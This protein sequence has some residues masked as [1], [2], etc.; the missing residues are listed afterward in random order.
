MTKPLRFAPLIRVST[1]KQEKKGESLNTQKIQIQD[2]VERLGGV[3][4]DN[5][6]RYSGQEHATQDQERVKL[7]NLLQDSSKGLFDAI[8]VTDASRWSRDNKKSEEGLEIL[9][10]NSIQF[11]TGMTEINLFNP[12]NVLLLK[13]SVV[14]GEFNANIQTSKSLHNRIERAKRGIPTGGKPPYG[15]IFNKQTL[16]WEIDPD[17]QKGI[18]YAARRYLAGG[19]IPKIAKT[20]GISGPYLQTVLSKRSG[21]NWEIRFKSDRLKIDET[22]KFKVPR[23]LPQKTID[24]VIEQAQ[25]NKTYTHGEIKNKYLL[26][27]MIFCDQC[28]YAMY[29]KTIS[30]GKKYYIHRKDKGTL[31]NW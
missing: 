26:S 13:M 19:S 5:C 11:F 8:I 22:V 30:S 6:G 9:K 18:E 27:R 31:I 12:E 23:L 3:I 21:E 4:P 16:G 24:A 15:R 28:G 7:D 2:Y 25:S 20:L 10:Q 14:F 1:E 29:G 17:K